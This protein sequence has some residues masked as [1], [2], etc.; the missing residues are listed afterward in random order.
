VKEPGALRF[1]ITAGPT[2]E[3][4]DPI[5]FISNRSSGKMGYALAE[6]ARA[7]S[8]HVVLVSGPTALARPKG[9]E[10]ISVMTTEEMA[11]AVLPRFEQCDIAIMAAAV[12]DFRPAIPAALKIKKAAFSGTLKLAPT[13]DILAKLGELKKTQILVGFAAETDNLERNALDKLKRKRLD[14]I[15]ANEAIA[16]EADTN[17]VTLFGKEG[18]PE[19]LTEMPKRQAAEAIVQRVLQ[20]SR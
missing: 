7:V 19:R 6:A 1:L 17:T 4:I 3:F 14:L 9:V 12:C 10:F 16:F 2:R 20:L 13:T 18:K 5:R 8:P 11:E 15:V